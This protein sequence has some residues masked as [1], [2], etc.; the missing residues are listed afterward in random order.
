MTYR[1][2]VSLK[3]FQT[4]E[5]YLENDIDFQIFFENHGK[6]KKVVFSQ[7]FFIRRDNGSGVDYLRFLVVVQLDV[8]TSCTSG[9]HLPPSQLRSTSSRLLID[10]SSSETFKSKIIIKINMKKYKKVSIWA[11]ELW[12]NNLGN[13][14]L[15]IIL[16]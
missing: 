9:S 1:H 11:L 14:K 10:E 7:R 2:V 13:V 16:Y 3:C 15:I 5:F 8:E 4:N 6:I 12:L